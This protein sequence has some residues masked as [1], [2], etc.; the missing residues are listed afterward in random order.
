MLDSG[1]IVVDAVV[2]TTPSPVLARLV[3]DL[4]DKYRAETRRAGVR[5]GVVAFL[6]LS[7]PLSDIYWL[8]IADDDLPFTGVIEHTNFVSPDEYGGKRFVYLSKYLEPDHPYFTMRMTADRNVRAI[9]ETDQSRIRPLLDR[10]GLGLSRTIGP[11]DHSSQLRSADSRPSHRTDGAL[12][13]Q[14]DPD[15]SGGPRHELQRTPRKSDCRDRRR[16]PLSRIRPR[17]TAV[18]R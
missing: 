12:S 13:G 17:L 10:T 1:E 11:A 18:R 5:G 8:N 4:P 7:R 15:L 6:Q 9:P 3:P 2:V 16:R 14:H